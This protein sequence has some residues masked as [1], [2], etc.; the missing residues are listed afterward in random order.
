[1]TKLV[2]LTA[3]SEETKTEGP[4]SQHRQHKDRLLALQNGSTQ[5]TAPLNSGEKL[6]PQLITY[7]SQN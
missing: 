5:V 7:Q 6:E 1:M 4:N 2:L 3:L